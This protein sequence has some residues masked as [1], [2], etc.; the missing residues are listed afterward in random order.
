MSERAGLHSIAGS[1]RA[2]S[3]SGGTSDLFASKPSSRFD[4]VA[5]RSA[6]ERQSLHAGGAPGRELSDRAESRKGTRVI[7]TTVRGTR[8]PP[9][10]LFVGGA[11]PQADANPRQS[12]T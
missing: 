7:E 10:S 2:G 4:V 11:R 6:G 9:R 5:R 3:A 8:R 1:E 12:A